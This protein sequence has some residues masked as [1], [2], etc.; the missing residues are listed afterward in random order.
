MVPKTR[1]DA[2]HFYE[3]DWDGYEELYDA[4]EWDVPEQ[5]NIA[6]YLCDRWADD[7]DRV[8]VHAETSEGHRRTYSFRRLQEEANKLANFLQTRGVERGDRVA[9]TGVQ[10]PET[11]VAHVATWKLG[12][13]S[14]PLSPLF[15]PD[16]LSYHLTDCSVSA[17]VTEDPGYGTLRE[18]DDD[19]PDLHTVVTTGKVDPDGNDEFTYEAALDE[20]STTFE[21]VTT[22]AEDDAIILYTSGTSGPPK[23]V[24]HAHQF[25]LGMLPFFVTCLCNYDI[26][27][28]DVAYVPAEWSWMGSLCSAA[29]N[30]LYYGNAVV[31]YSG[32][33]DPEKVFE[34]LDRYG[35]TTL[36]APNSILRMMKDQVNDAERFDT[37]ALRAIPT[38]GEAL[39]QSVVEWVDRVLDAPLNQGFG[40]TEYNGITT[41][42]KGL[43]V[44]RTETLGRPI[45]GHEPAILDPETA[46][47][48]IS[49]GEIGEIGVQGNTPMCFKRYW[50]KPEKTDA[51]FHDGWLLTGDLGWK[52]EESH[53]HYKARK[54]FVILSGG[55]RIGPEEIEDC[56]GEHP[57]VAD[58][59]VIGVPHDTRGEIPKA[60][61]QLSKDTTPSE[62]LRP[63]LK[64]HVKHRLAKYKYPRQ[65][66]FIDELPKTTNGKIQR[67]ALVEREGL[68]SK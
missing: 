46:D 19:L 57:A 35:V 39:D 24:L 62:E 36:V 54:D 40:Q 13:V 15:G 7:P 30:S 50:E 56:L 65:I 48:T 44:Y 5:F 25:Q 58:S 68:D 9:V 31:A 29:M 10:K 49:V 16:S 42:C 17:Y 6:T 2:Y 27:N 51:V 14:V 20:R 4:F 64:A 21:T 60:F 43:G 61:V 66:E 41:N 11:L 37:S 53:Y 23:G 47:P 33:F 55:H 45:P 38:G 59:G 34:F 28:E 22:A 63:N 1:I 52:D 32:R 26:T 12:A 8:A 67:N 3:D 18:L